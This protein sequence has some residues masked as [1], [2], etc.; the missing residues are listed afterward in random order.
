MKDKVL[1]V[2]RRFRTAVAGA[3]IVSIAM[4]GIAS[5]I[6]ARA[7]AA[8]TSYP[9]T[10]DYTNN[11]AS[12]SL[13][14]ARR[15]NNTTDYINCGVT[16]QFAYVICYAVSG[17]TAAVCEMV[18]PNQDWRIVDAIQML[19]ESSYIEFAWN[20]QGKCTEVTVRNSSR[21]LP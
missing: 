5:P 8:S 3:A 10:I 4:A 1:S 14:T 6:T 16:R 20:S 12:G 13:K 15:S 7:G 2:S 17:N 11:K 9:V 18:N 19:N 21:H